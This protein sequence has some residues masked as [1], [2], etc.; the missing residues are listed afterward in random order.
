MGAISERHV[1]SVIVVVKSKI[2]HCV[3]VF[4]KIL[5][6]NSSGSKIVPSIGKESMF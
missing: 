5:K 4:T 2:I 1:V 3:G 6:K